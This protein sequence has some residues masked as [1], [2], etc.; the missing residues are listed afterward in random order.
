VIEHE[1]LGTRRVGAGQ[2][3]T[4]WG[5]ATRVN[6]RGRAFANGVAEAVNNQSDS[7]RMSDPSGVLI[8]PAGSPRP[9]AEGKTGREL[10]TG[11]RR[12]LRS[13]VPLRP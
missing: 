2:G 6:P 9:R 13:A 10:L 12:R 5:T 11:A 4:L 1:R 8:V 7:Y 3:A